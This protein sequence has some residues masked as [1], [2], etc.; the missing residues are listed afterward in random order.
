[1][2][3]PFSSSYSRDSLHDRF[4][5]SSGRYD[6]TGAAPQVETYQAPQN[7]VSPDEIQRAG[8]SM[9]DI[10]SYAGA[11]A[12]GGVAARNSVVTNRAVG[13]YL[14]ASGQSPASRFKLGDGL[15]KEIS[16]FN[17]F[18]KGMNDGKGLRSLK[19]D[20]FDKTYEA[21]KAQQASNAA[22]NA[23]NGANAATQA[24]PDLDK[25]AKMDDMSKLKDFDHFPDKN[26]K[27][28]PDTGR[29]WDG[30]SGHHVGSFDVD[31]GDLKLINSADN[32]KVDADGFRTDLSDF[33]VTDKGIF[34]DNGA[35]VVDNP[36]DFVKQDFGGK[37]FLVDDKTRQIFDPATRQ[38][39][40]MVDDYGKV[41]LGG[42]NSPVDADG[43]R[44]N[45][46]EFDWTKDNKLINADGKNVQLVADKS[47]L[48][49]LDGSTSKAGSTVAKEAGEKG[50]QTAVK[51]AGEKG[52]QA[53]TRAAAQK[54]GKEVVE[55]AGEKAVKQLAH[56]EMYKAGEKMLTGLGEQK[57]KGGLGRKV[58]RGTL[59]KGTGLVSSTAG[60]NIAKYG[61]KGAVQKATGVA[62]RELG[63]KGFKESAKQFGKSIG[64][65]ALGK[66][67]MAAGLSLAAPPVGAVVGAAL[68]IWAVYD[69]AQLAFG[70]FG[71]D[72]WHL[73]K[74][75]GY[76]SAP[77]GDMHYL[78]A[79]ANFWEDGQEAVDEDT[80]TKNQDDI[81]HRDN[82]KYFNV[83]EFRVPHRKDCNDPITELYQ[84]TPTLDSM[85]TSLKQIGDI[86][87]DLAG[88]MQKYKNDQAI[89]KYFAARPELSEVLTNATISS[90]ITTINN[91]ANNTATHL[92]N[93]YTMWS[94][95]VIDSK[96]LIVE[97]EGGYAPWEWAKRDGETL[98]YNS[99]PIPA[100]EVQKMSTDLNNDMDAIREYSTAL[101]GVS[102]PT[103]DNRSHIVLDTPSLTSPT[104]PISHQT[105]RTPSSP[106]RPTKPDT[107]T[108]PS[109]DTTK[110]KPTVPGTP[111]AAPAGPKPNA[112]VNKDPLKP[113]PIKPVSPNARPGMPTPNMPKPHSPIA[114]NGPRPNMF[115]PNNGPN[116]GLPS[117][118]DQQRAELDKQRR[119][120]EARRR[121]EQ[122]KA[123]EAKRKEDQEKKKA[124]EQKKRDEEKKRF[125]EQRKKAEDKNKTPTAPKPSSA[126]DT[127]DTKKA[128]DEKKDNNKPKAPVPGA[129]GDTTDEKPAD[130]NNLADNPEANKEDSKPGENGELPKDPKQDTEKTEIKRGG[131]T[132]DVKDPKL[133]TIADKVNPAEGETATPL[134]EAYK[135]QGY[136]VPED[137]KAP[138]GK[139]IPPTEIQPGDVVR[140]NGQEGMYLGEKK[141]LTTNGVVNLSDMADFSESN[142]GIFRVEGGADAAGADPHT[143]MDIPETPSDNARLPHVEGPE[144]KAMGTDVT[145]DEPGDVPPGGGEASGDGAGGQS[146]KDAFAGIGQDPKDTSGMGN[147]MGN[148]GGMGNM[149][150][151][152]N[153]GGHS[154]TPKKP[155]GGEAIGGGGGT[156]PN[157]DGPSW[158]K[159]PESGKRPNIITGD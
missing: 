120:D 115:G 145:P 73:G 108:T 152:G 76:D 122:R 30:N 98:D 25:V 80:Y 6:T 81:L 127:K 130:P 38:N 53:A 7:I 71:T 91:L 78:V 121:E 47:R 16:D 153:T 72:V 131:K 10:A 138:I 37:D 2:N 142:D 12:W 50:A 69:F 54:A 88:T 66:L 102:S 33:K 28:D 159:S 46:T 20:D 67:G 107:V 87:Q 52:A 31:K 110:P 112:P 125:D 77:T 79:W 139:P 90:T 154:V 60:R 158:Q 56:R 118:F 29:L 117:V 44:Q 111:T 128:E 144:D 99:E 123:D 35:R 61:V 70:F 36:S 114:P 157:N 133:A 34:A 94:N 95:T 109:A 92:N 146:S 62:L 42:K 4:V 134:R 3:T 55:E 75:P 83:D 135:E 101:S 68:A 15:K 64:K 113:N 147:G 32:I 105:P 85:G 63:E 119:E 116:T 89:A 65:K 57:L 149:G 13:Q 1:M 129:P 11:G 141:V 23:T 18:S 14:K 19:K 58:V 22:A 100:S 155:V 21:F 132:F 9:G 103:S 143:P 151:G 51:E 59:S 17:K 140:G 156:T 49:N 41:H 126:P 24:T 74:A 150:G 26:L 97:A 86:E 40:G 5:P 136:T 27:F 106:S 43:Y 137:P 48:H 93:L 39:V 124:E 84:D 8:F 148:T 96:R 82:Q 45:L 104:T